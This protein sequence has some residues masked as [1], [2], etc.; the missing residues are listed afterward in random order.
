MVCLFPLPIRVRHSHPGTIAARGWNRCGNVLGFSCSETAP[1]HRHPAFAHLS[2]SAC[3]SKSL[4][5]PL[6][7][8]MQ[9]PLCFDQNTIYSTIHPLSSIF[10]FLRNRPPRAVAEP[11]ARRAAAP[12]PEVPAIRSRSLMWQLAASA[13]LTPGDSARLRPVLPT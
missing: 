13:S 3:M 2:V 12:V 6:A 7:S 5:V 1:R 11:G 8:F 9:I 10:R 4:V